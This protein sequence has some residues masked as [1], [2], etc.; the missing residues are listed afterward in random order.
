M[1]GVP[2]IFESLAA[3][4]SFSAVLT[5]FRFGD[6]DLELDIHDFLAKVANDSDTVLVLLSR[7]ALE[8]GGTGG[9]S[10]GV[11]SIRSAELRRSGLPLTF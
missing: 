3:G 1:I 6:G 5:I 10:V 9:T 11:V 4:P 7:I 2:V 8:I